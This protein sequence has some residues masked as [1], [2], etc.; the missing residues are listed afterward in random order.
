MES[1]KFNSSSEMLAFLEECLSQSNTE[2]ALTFCRDECFKECLETCSWDLIPLVT[3]YFSD[4]VL[5]NKRDLFNCCEEIV[6]MIAQKSPPEEMLLVLIDEAE[7]LV[8]VKLITLLKPIQKTLLRLKS[9]LDVSVEWCFNSIYRHL[10]LL[11]IPEDRNLEGDER[12]LLDSDPSV[13]RVRN[14]YSVVMPFYEPFVDLVVDKDSKLNEKQKLSIRTAILRS[15]FRLLGKPLIY[16]DLESSEEYQSQFYIIC[17][18][19]LAHIINLSKNLLCHL[20]ELDT[21]NLNNEDVAEI[22]EQLRLSVK[23]S[24]SFST[25]EQVSPI[26]LGLLYYLVFSEKIKLD[27]IPMV[28]SPLFLLEKC[29][30]LSSILLKSSISL[31]QRKG[32]LLSN[33]VLDRIYDAS[34]PRYILESNIYS[35]FIEGLFLTAVYCND[36]DNRTLAVSTIG[37]F[38]NKF[39]PR[40]QYVLLVKMVDNANHAGLVGYLATLYKT[41][42]NRIL[43]KKESDDENFFNSRNVKY[44]LDKFCD[45]PHKAA[46]DLVESS[47]QIISS[48]N[49]IRFLLLRDTENRFGIW[50]YINK[51]NDNF[52]VPV[53]DGIN[54]SRAHY[55]VKLDDL[56]KEIVQG[57]SN[58]SKPAESVVSITIG[59]EV[60]PNM[61]P[62]GKLAVI[63]SAINTFDLIESVLSRVNE[64]INHHQS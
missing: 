36:K 44:L 37:K 57:R 16:M 47:D 49:L 1:K 64:I 7:K 4:D 50:G 22:L 27:F 29:V 26:S 46:T 45:L 6:D 39:G 52:L 5:R 58:K 61:P 33:S 43:S 30:Y 8:D 42:L 40:G 12:K 63:Q 60:L 24:D 41:L 51:L 13:R 20:E 19:L 14:I 56:N 10:L 38:L 2:T 48:L 32:L 3:K 9:R 28:Y 31:I 34:A 11:P 62:A 35:H 23:S 54:L 21:D 15:C 59:N 25:D 17:E 53:R 18:K 55:E